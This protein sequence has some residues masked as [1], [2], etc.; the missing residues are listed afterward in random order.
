MSR[1]S[2]AP[3]NRLLAMRVSGD[4]L[5]HGSRSRWVRSVPML[6]VRISYGCMQWRR[7]AMA[8]TSL[9]PSVTLTPRRLHSSSCHDLSLPTTAP[10]CERRLHL[11]RLSV[12][13]ASPQTEPYWCL[14]EMVKAVATLPA[15][16]E[17]VP[18]DTPVANRLRSA[19]VAAVLVL[20]GGDT[21][22][23]IHGLTEEVSL[24]VAFAWSWYTGPLVE[25]FY[26]RASS[27]E[28]FRLLRCSHKSG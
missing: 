7:P 12:D 26:H 1:L 8:P 11:C 27:L 21:T 18:G 4:L 24:H 2:R 3:A 14:N 19:H 13:R 16:C 20:M 17:G 5:R 25:A 15:L 6:K 23:S 22:P 10:R 9:P 28:V